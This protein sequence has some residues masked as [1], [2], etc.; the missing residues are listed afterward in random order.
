[1]LVCKEVPL[2]FVPLYM[3][4][5]SRLLFANFPPLSL[6]L[7][8][9]YVPSLLNEDACVNTQEYKHCSSYHFYTNVD[10]GMCTLLNIESD[11]AHFSSSR[12]CTCL[13]SRIVP[14]PLLN[15]HINNTHTHTSQP[16]IVSTVGRSISFHSRNTSTFTGYGLSS[17]THSS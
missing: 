7:S 6:S 13:D 9:F 16:D 15:I 4:G 3:F 12:C 1:M 5:L 14:I 2:P 17:L 10:C 11:F 8:C